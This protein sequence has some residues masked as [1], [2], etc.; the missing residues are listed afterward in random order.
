MRVIRRRRA[1]EKQLPLR[2]AHAGVPGALRGDH[3]RDAGQVP[4]GVERH[5]RRALGRGRAR[6]GLRAR[7]VVGVPVQRPRR[8]QRAEGLQGDHDPDPGERVPGRLPGDGPARAAALPAGAQPVPVARRGR[9]LDPGGGRAGP[10][11]PERAHRDRPDRLRRRPRQ[12]GAGRA[13]AGDAR[14]PAEELEPLLRGGAR[15]GLHPARLARDREG[16]RGPDEDV[17]GHVRADDG[18]QGQPPAGHDRRAGA[19]ADQR[20]DAARPGAARGDR[21][22]H[23]GRV[24]HHDR[25]DRALAR[26]AVGAPG[27]AVAVVGANAARCSTRR[28]RSSCASTPRRRATG[29]RSR[30]TARSRGPSSRRASGSGCRGRCPTATRRSSPTRTRSTWPAP[31]TG[32]TASASAFTAASGPTWPGWCSSGC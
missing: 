30:P 29:G 16:P 12:R 13:H 9:A 11:L 6:R 21:A 22:G 10:R 25:A 17:P 32:T 14:G 31:A 24:R 27:R 26:V 28:P 19:G 7:P 3:D 23:R 4:G 1:Q 15:L 20:Q 5:L 8:E 2:P 18:D